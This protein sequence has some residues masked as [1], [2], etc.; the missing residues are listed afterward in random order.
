VTQEQNRSCRFSCATNQIE[1]SLRPSSAV[2]KV[3][4]I[5]VE[6]A[7]IVADE[8]QGSALPFIGRMTQQA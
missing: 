3:V 1:S 4:N 5:L 7:C 8:Y 6:C 2:G